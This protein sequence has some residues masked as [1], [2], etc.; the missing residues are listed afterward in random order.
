M[1]IH[2]SMYPSPD[3]ESAQYTDSEDRTA[4]LVMFQVIAQRG[5]PA[6]VFPV[7]DSMSRNTYF[8]E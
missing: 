4:I 1:L 5:I 2:Q 6:S 3:S 7:Q 8:V